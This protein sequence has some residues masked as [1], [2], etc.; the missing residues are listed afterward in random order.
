MQTPCARAAIDTVKCCQT[1]SS[2]ACTICTNAVSPTWTLY[3]GHEHNLL[4]VQPYDPD[5]P[6]SSNVMKWEFSLSLKLSEIQVQFI[7]NGTIS[8]NVMKWYHFY[9]EL[10][11]ASRFDLQAL[12]QVGKY[13]RTR[14]STR[15]NCLN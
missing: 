6:N 10:I 2:S 5:S 8:S 4:R 7:I 1:A 9:V 14:A 13:Q 12:L 15:P 11:E 3:P